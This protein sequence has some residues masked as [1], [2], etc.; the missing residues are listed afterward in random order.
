MAISCAPHANSNVPYHQPAG[1]F[2][3]QLVRFRIVCNSIQAFKYATTQLTL[4]LLARG[5]KPATLMKGWNKHLSK[6]CNDSRAR[7]IEIAQL[8]TAY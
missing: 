5:H 4:K 1:V 2:Q 7:E 3:G 8:V 6:L